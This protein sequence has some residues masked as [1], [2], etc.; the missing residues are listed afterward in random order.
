[1][2]TIVT[3]LDREPLDA[4]VWRVTGAGVAAVAMVLAANAG[5]AELAL[6][7]P[8]G[9]TVVIPEIS[10]TSATIDLIQLWD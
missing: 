7:L 3:A 9:T 2:T 10:A 4:L 5:L 1:M 8:L 6:A